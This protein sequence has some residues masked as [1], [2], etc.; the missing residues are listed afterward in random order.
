MILRKADAVGIPASAVLVAPDSA[1]EAAGQKVPLISDL[2][3][4]EFLWTGFSVSAAIEIIGAT[5][6]AILIYAKVRELW[7]G[8]NGRS[9]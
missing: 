2:A 7:R 4:L 9:E 8:R 6:I 5:Y 1:K 3:Q